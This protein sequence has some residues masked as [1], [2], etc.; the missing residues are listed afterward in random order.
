MRVNAK[1]VASA[2]AAAA[3]V[4]LRGRLGAELDTSQGQLILR[5]TFTWNKRSNS[6]TYI[7]INESKETA[8]TTAV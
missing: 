4:H 1:I 6:K 8:P 3:V 7:Y 2:I 5:N